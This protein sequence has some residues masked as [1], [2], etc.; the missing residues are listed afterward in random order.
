[1]ISLHA[2]SGRRARQVLAVLSCWN[3]DLEWSELTSA[4]LRTQNSCLLPPPHPPMMGEDECNNLE[5]TCTIICH[6]LTDRNHVYGNQGDLIEVSG[7]WC[8][9]WRHTLNSL[10]VSD[11]SSC[12]VH[13]KCSYRAPGWLLCQQLHSFEETLHHNVFLEEGSVHFGKEKETG[14]AVNSGQPG[15]KGDPRR[16][17]DQSV[18]RPLVW[19]NN[20]QL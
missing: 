20:K 7:V 9:Q 6:N 19:A 12:S 13:L 16:F 10:T 1:M 8:R 15:C 2:Q 14:G 18:S 5:R 3:D 4:Q 11:G 17:P